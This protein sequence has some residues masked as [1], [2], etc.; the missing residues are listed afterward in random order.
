MSLILFLQGALGEKIAGRLG[1][2]RP[3]IYTY[4]AGATRRASDQRYMRDGYPVRYIH[5]RKF[6]PDKISISPDDIVI[7]ADW[8]KDFFHDTPHEF[9]VYHIH[10]SLLPAY[11]GYGA[12]STQFLRGVAIGGVTLY[13]DNGT[14]DGGPIALQEMIPIA[15]GDYSDDYL[16]KCANITSQWL[17]RI[18]IDGCP[19]M[20]TPQ[21]ELSAIYTQ[22]LRHRDMLVDTAL[23]APYFYNAVR[24]FSR[25]FSGSF[26]YR[27]GHKITIW[28]CSIEKW[29]G[30]QA[31]HG[32]IITRGK[33]GVE[34][35]CGE[36][37]VMITEIE[38]DGKIYIFDEMND[39]L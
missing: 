11:R 8:S 6:D 3:A 19:A 14:I 21:D 10:P 36:G 29:A 39:I 26:I 24:A 23:A 27:K 9:A 7:C 18:Y 2:L 12:V 31:A 25:P 13:A 28:K 30:S 33:F 1:D 15:P 34:L 16:T 22:R 37:S 5:E 4:A 32:S 17:R 35:A 38:I 20:L